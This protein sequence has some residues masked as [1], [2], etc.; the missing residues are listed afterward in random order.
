[1]GGGSE[2][3][4][5][6]EE[7]VDGWMREKSWKNDGS[8]TNKVGSSHGSSIYIIIITCTSPSFAYRE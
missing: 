7:E 2:G 6:R 1:M 5:G 4:W 3:G 8:G